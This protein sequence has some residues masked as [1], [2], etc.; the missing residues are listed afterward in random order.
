MSFRTRR[1]YDL[2]LVA[3]AVVILAACSSSS[4]GSGSGTS[5][6]G[7]G[8]CT[9]ADSPVITL[10][11][12]SNVYDVYG[13]LIST[14]QSDWADKHD[15]QQ[16]IFST[17]FGGSTT[18]AQNVVNGFPAD[19]VALSLAPD[20]KL[21]QDAGLITHDWQADADHGFVGSSAVVFDVRPGNPKGIHDWSDLTQPG[22]QI[23]TPD[24]AQSG[25][26]KW[27]IVA[28]YGAA[29]RGKE[30]G[31][32]ANNPADAEKLLQGIFT[33]VTVMDKSANDSLKN[34]QAGNGD[35]AISY[36]Y[37][38][39]TAQHSGLPDVMVMPPSTVAI[40][41]PVAVVDKNATADCVE[42]VANAFV[43]F[44]HTPDAQAIY[45]SVGYERPVDLTKAQAGK[46][47]ENTYEPVKDYF[48][49]DDLG[50]WD[51]LLNDTVFGTNGAF[52]QALQAAQG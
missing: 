7:G 31:Y 10:A 1:I 27:N 30:T 25:G 26:A 16:V 46:G 50:G 43:T 23:L 15:G 19:V 32:A 38:V 41:T 29:M 34:F 3:L 4:G 52:T 48:T 11:A 42:D 6:G 20:V 47:V 45:D 33:N 44:L 8:S 14:F 51:A 21:I 24:P 2:S 36:E 5:A 37:A 13:K 49:T 39:L 18:Q 28:A 40:Q 12:Y 17:S 9:P 22:L 35:V